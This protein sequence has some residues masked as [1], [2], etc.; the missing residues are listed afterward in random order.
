M[1]TKKGF[2]V[3]CCFLSVGAIIYLVTIADAHIAVLIV[4]GSFSGCTIVMLNS[5]YI[6]CLDEVDILKNKVYTLKEEVAQVTRTAEVAREHEL[7]ARLNVGEP[8]RAEQL[9]ALAHEVADSVNTF[10]V[11]P[12]CTLV[13]AVRPDKHDTQVDVLEA[14][15]AGAGELA[16]HVNVLVDAAKRIA[17]DTTADRTADTTADRTADTTADTTADRTADTTVR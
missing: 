13:I 4:L 9:T 15:A 7:A 1:W 12:G 2:V 8:S 11:I 5:M 16:A 3:L 10:T 14:N 17:A 6:E